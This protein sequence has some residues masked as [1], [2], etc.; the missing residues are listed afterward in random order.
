M[1]GGVWVDPQVAVDLVSTTEFMSRTQDNL[2]KS[3][4]PTTM[5]VLGME[6]RL[7]DLAA[8]AFSHWS[9]QPARFCFFDTGSKYTAQTGLELVILLAQRSH[10]WA[11][12]HAVPSLALS[13][14]I[15]CLN[16]LSPPLL[17]TLLPSMRMLVATGPVGSAA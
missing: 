10:S 13:T 9:I 5:W 11:P 6:V 2:W 1:E 17:I 12:R 8:R 14:S 7:S 4:L 3:V 15:S 16:C